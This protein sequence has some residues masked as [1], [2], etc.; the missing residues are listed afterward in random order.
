GARWESLY[1]GS[2]PHPALS[3]C[4]G[5]VTLRNLP[6]P[7]GSGS[8]WALALGELLLCQRAHGVRVS[9]RLPAD[10]HDSIADDGQH[11]VPGPAHPRGRRSGPC[12]SR[13]ADG[14]RLD[15]S[16][17]VDVPATTAIGEVGGLIGMAGTHQAID[18]R[19]RLIPVDSNLAHG[20][21]VARGF[22]FIR[23]WLRPT[24]TQA[25]ERLVKRRQAFRNQPLAET[26]GGLAVENVHTALRKDR[27]GIDPR[28][29]QVAGDA[30]P[31]VA[32]GDRPAEGLGAPVPSQQ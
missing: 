28:L 1:G 17:R 22:K 12:P 8:G 3:S 18:L 32:V 10:G 25:I 9:D 15:T 20:T 31:A 26:A 16:N 23:D 21:F 24:R 27:T 29:R 30:R 14:I 19:E 4:N 2:A 11:L 7:E 13:F 5:T 6:P